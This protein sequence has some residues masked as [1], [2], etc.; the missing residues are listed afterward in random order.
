MIKS[1]KKKK[2]SGA[3]KIVLEILFWLNTFFAHWRTNLLRL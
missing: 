1:K 2:Q 3:L